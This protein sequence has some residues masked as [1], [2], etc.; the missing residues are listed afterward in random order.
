MTAPVAFS[1]RFLRCGLL[2]VAIAGL[3]FQARAEELKIEAKL[4]WGTND[5]TSPDASHKPVDKELAK[6]LGNIFKWKNYFEVNRVN[7]TIPSRGTRKLQMSKACTVEITEV[8]GPKVEVTLF[9]K[10][11]MVNRTVESLS[12]G[13]C[14][15]IGGP[16]KNE[17]AWFVVV[18]QL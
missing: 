9:G 18:T 3:A 2:V 13:G 5:D 12:K 10:G 14:F 1:K 16:D 11:K 6:R 17:T 7:A 8:A 15:T 4:I